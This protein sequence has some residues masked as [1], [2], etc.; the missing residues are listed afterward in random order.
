[1]AVKTIFTS[2]DFKEILSR[3]NVGEFIRSKPFAEGADQTNLLLTTTL[4]DVVLRYYEKR[5]F[6][7]VDFEVELLHYLATHAYPTAGPLANREGVYIGV[8]KEK[9]FALFEFLHGEHSDNPDN[10]LQVAEIYGTLHQLTINY[11]PIRGKMRPIYN[12]EYCWAW[13][14]KSAERINSQVEA[15]DRLAWIRKELDQLDLPVS[16]PHGVCHGDPN[17]TNFLYEQGK[18]S[19]VL[20]FDQASYTWLLY[21]LAH[22]ITW[23]TWPDMGD[24][25]LVLSRKLVSQYESKCPMTE[26]EHLHLFDALKLVLLVSIGW[27]LDEDDSLAN[28]RRKI[29][30][31]N[32]LG[33]ESFYRHFFEGAQTAIQ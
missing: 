11:R 16:L 10:Y 1:M 29:D 26:S 9:P 21:D 12:Q 14:Q 4:R 13:A 32:A 24:I 22:M 25:D 28:V 31:L 3:Y 20:D 7:Y 18:L 5:T 30:S 2:D 15:Q 27:F 8:Y 17:P 6:N 23:W 19:G 33:P